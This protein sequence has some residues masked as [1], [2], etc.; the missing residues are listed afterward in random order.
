M[1]RFANRDTVVFADWAFWVF[2]NI[3][4]RLDTYNSKRDPSAF[5][6]RAAPKAFFDEEDTQ[7]ETW[8][9]ERLGKVRYGHVT[10]VAGG[11]SHSATLR[12]LSDKERKPVDKAVNYLIKRK[13][14]MPYG[15]LPAAGTPIGSGIIEGAC[16]HLICNRLQRAGARWT[17]NRA[18]AEM[19]L[20]ALVANGDFAAYWGGATN[21]ASG[22][23]TM[24]YATLTATCRR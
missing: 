13:R 3:T 19:Q 23:E 10:E 18:E 9:L 21:C 24:S 22:N 5:I 1:A 6:R 8:V 12:G 14:M 7:R 4:S 15:E 20:R 2:H 16:R 17:L 11:M